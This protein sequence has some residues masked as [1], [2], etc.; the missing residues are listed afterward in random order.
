MKVEVDY[1]TRADLAAV[2]TVPH[3]R[4]SALAGRS[5]EG[6]VIGVG[7]LAYAADGRVFAWADLTEE[8]RKHP[9]ALHKAGLRAMRMARESGLRRLVATTDLSVTPAGARWLA[10]LGF[11]RE[12]A[13]GAEIW[14][15]RNDDLP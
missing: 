9:V 14:V 10:R 13:C 11:K 4:V 5:P 3:C 8:A 6:Q 12:E 1:A 2:G 7:G 15:W